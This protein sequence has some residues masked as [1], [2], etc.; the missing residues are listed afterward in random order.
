MRLCEAVSGKSGLFH[1]VVED[2]LNTD[3]GKPGLAEKSGLKVGD[4][5]L[6][7]SRENIVGLNLSGALGVVREQCQAATKNK[8][9][10]ITVL[11]VRPQVILETKSQADKKTA[12]EKQYRMVLANMATREWGVKMFQSLWRRFTGFNASNLIVTRL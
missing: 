2:L 4:V 12:E 6:T 7:V 11:V 8:T 3:N 1:V 9:K 5:L 10:K